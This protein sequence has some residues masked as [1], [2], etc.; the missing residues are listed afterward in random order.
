MYQDL[1]QK[2]IRQK[3]PNDFNFIFFHLGIYRD[4]TMNSKFMYKLNFDKQTY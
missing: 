4:K 3:V 1:R 2:S